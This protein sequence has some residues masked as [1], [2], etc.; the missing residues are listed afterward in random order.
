MTLKWTG[1]PR[2]DATWTRFKIRRS[3]AEKV[4][5]FQAFFLALESQ[6]ILL[7]GRQRL[8]I[9]TESTMP[10]SKKSLKKSSGNL[11]KVSSTALGNLQK[12]SGKA[13][14]NFLNF[15]EISQKS[16]EK[17]SKNQAKHPETYSA[18]ENSGSSRQWSGSMPTSGQNSDDFFDKTENFCTFCGSSDRHKIAV[19]PLDFLKL[20]RQKGRSKWPWNGLSVPDLTRPEPGSKWGVRKPK[21]LPAFKPFSWRSKARKSSFLAGKDSWSGLNQQCQRPRNL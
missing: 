13:P 14:V 20:E 1:R 17:A 4:T 10:A 18:D 11:Q 8:L 7:F 9:R 2:S 21:K 6:K 15:W 19:R 5:C 12:M 16:E 3:K